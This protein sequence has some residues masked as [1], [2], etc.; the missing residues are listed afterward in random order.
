MKSKILV[1]LFVILAICSLCAV[2]LLPT[3]GERTLK[4]SMKKGVSSE[5]IDNLKHRFSG[6]EIV[7]SSDSEIVFR[8]Y[9]ITDAKMN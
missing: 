5:Q 3:F 2:F 9:G 1:R 4:V 6:K 7:S 8:G